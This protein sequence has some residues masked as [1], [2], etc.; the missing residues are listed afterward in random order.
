MANLEDTQVRRVLGGEEPGRSHEALSRMLC[1]IYTPY[2][3]LALARESPSMNS[4]PADRL[5][6]HVPPPDRI[7]R[8]QFFGETVDYLDRR[9]LVRDVFFLDLLGSRP[10]HARSIDA[11]ARIFGVDIGAQCNA[12]S[13]QNDMPVTTRRCVLPAEARRMETVERLAQMLGDGVDA[14]SGEIGPPERSVRQLSAEICESFVIRK[15]AQVAGTILEEPYDA[16]AFGQIWL[17]RPIAAPS[18]RVATK[19]LHLHH[20]TKGR[21]LRYFRRGCRAMQA[22]EAARTGQAYES[23]VKLLS[24]SADTLAFS[25]EFYPHGNLVDIKRLGWDLPTKLVKWRQICEAIG[26]AHRVG[27]I[28]RDIR[29]ANIVLDADD[30]PVITDFDIADAAFFS[31]A[32]VAWN[33]GSEA[34]ASPEQRSRGRK[35]GSPT[36]DVYSLGRLLHFLLIEREPPLTKAE[37]R[38]SL[39]ECPPALVS[40]IARA[41]SL[42][43][44]DRYT[45]VEQLVSA[46]DAFTGALARA[47]APRRRLGL[48]RRSSTVTALGVSVFS[49]FAEGLT[50]ERALTPTSWTA[51]DEPDG[52]LFDARRFG[53]GD[54]PLLEVPRPEAEPIELVDPSEPVPSPAPARRRKRRKPEP[55]EEL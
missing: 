33:L 14:E 41:T 13:R 36:D 23:I 29:P 46:L 5:A 49:M 7:S 53:Y 18:K 20:L 35:R 11:A 6:D 3:F 45:D 27:V 39:A 26:F 21:F 8:A 48:L 22:L 10:L 34:F 42:Q 37:V 9:G 16:G 4:S 32:S 55:V 47:A 38:G 25:M 1:F 12:M 43:A 50:G 2:E 19:I 54:P 17:A 31:D 52:E 40:I 28:H 51:D 24:V 30:N 15:G 44:R